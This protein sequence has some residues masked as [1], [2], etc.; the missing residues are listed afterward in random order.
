[1]H[2]TA[3]HLKGRTIEIGVFFAAA[4]VVSFLG[5]PI[6]GAGLVMW[7]FYTM[8][9]DE[10]DVMEAAKAKH[11]GRVTADLRAILAAKPDDAYLAFKM[12]ED[13]GIPTYELLDMVKEASTGLPQAAQNV[14]KKIEVKVTG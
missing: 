4:I 2:L 5:W 7:A 3:F 12:G 14:V 9:P 8:L 6:L 1:M 10:A 11:R 13:A